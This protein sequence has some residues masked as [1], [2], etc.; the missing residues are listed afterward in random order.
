MDNNLNLRQIEVERWI[1]SKLDVEEY[2]WLLESCGSIANF[3]CFLDGLV[4]KINESHQLN[5]IEFRVC[6]K[7]GLIKQRKIKTLT[8]V[9]MEL[10]KANAKLVE[11]E[12][13]FRICD[14]KLQCE[15]KLIDIH[16]YIEA[17]WWVLGNHK[18]L[19]ES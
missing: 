8:E 12:E 3:V 17:L 15:R 10:Q 1:R 11:L 14:D 4:N 7:L 6:Y 18:S 2:A 9:K 5:E 19:A 13:E 16:G